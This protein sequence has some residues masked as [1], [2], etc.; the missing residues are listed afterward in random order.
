MCYIRLMQR[1]TIKGKLPTLNDATNKARTHWAIAAKQKKEATEL[2]A[3]QCKRM[4]KITSPVFITFHWFVSSN[5]DADNIRH[6]AKYL[7]DGMILSK[8]LPNDNQKWV[9][10]FHGDYFTKVAKGEEKVIVE[11]D[12]GLEF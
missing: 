11:I 3:W 12:D 6:G 2:V 4:K 5:H 8:K 7:L 10:G 1:V 9:L